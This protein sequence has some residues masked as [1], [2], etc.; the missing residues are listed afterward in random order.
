[1]AAF[2]WKGTV[3]G[4]GTVKT[5]VMV[6]FVGS[7]LMVNVRVAPERGGFGAQRNTHPPVLQ[8]E[9]AEDALCGGLKMSVRTGTLGPDVIGLPTFLT[10][11]V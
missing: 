2:D 8:L 7:A 11:S 6:E 5:V 9:G 3:N 4:G 10:D 1:V